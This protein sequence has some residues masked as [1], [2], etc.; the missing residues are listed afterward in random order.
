MTHRASG[1]HAE[2]HRKNTAPRNPSQYQQHSKAETHPHPPTHQAGRALCLRQSETPTTY[3]NSMAW[4]NALA[5]IR[6]ESEASSRR[7]CPRIVLK[8]YHH[9][10]KTRGS[11]S[12]PLPKNRT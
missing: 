12:F 2:P 11:S 6:L 5:R 10:S 3:P 9:C 1:N 7:N 8:K 4:L